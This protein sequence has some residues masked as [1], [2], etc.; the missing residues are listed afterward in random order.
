MR[1][2]LQGAVE[3]IIAVNRMERLLKLGDEQKPELKS[4]EE[5]K[6]AEQAARRFEDHLAHGSQADTQV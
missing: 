6:K 1:G 5:M 2:A 3:T 4:P